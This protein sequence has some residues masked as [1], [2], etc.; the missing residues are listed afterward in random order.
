MKANLAFGFGMHN[1]IGINL[2]RHE[3]RIFLERILD[4]IPEYE[5]ATD[6]IDYGRHFMARGP[7][8]VPIA[9]G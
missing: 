3:I 6:E 4:A 8:A 1:C 2:A 7:L 5:L 9:A